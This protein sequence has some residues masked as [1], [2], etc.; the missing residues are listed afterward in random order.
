[1]CFGFDGFAPLRD[2]ARRGTG[3]D[4]RSLLRGAGAALVGG[5]AALGGVAAP[6]SAGPVATRGG[7]GRPVPP[8]QISI[9]MY[10]LRSI[11]NAGTV[12]DV[13][14]TL[15]DIGYRKVELAGTYGYSATDL[16]A[17]LVSH[18]ISA[19]S[20]H[21]GISSGEEAMHTKFENAVTLG[22]RF[23]NVPYLR[24]TS[25]DQWRQWADRMN[26]EAAVARSYGIHYGYHNHAHEFSEVLDDGSRAWDI[27]TDRL[28]PSLVHLEVDL[29][30]AV[31]GGLQTGEATEETASQFAA[32]VIA[33]APQKTL[34]Y[35]VKDREP[36]LDPFAGNAFADVGTGFVDFPQIF[37]DHMVKEFIVENDRP[38]IDPITTARVGYDYLRT[39][40]AE[41]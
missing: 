8:G 10:T 22:Q 25:A 31:T 38:D 23:L 12:D 41:R 5:A 17:L 4:R 40:R 3:P 21:D 13:L 9:Q 20:S 29:F 37:G 6:A 15:S 27:F 35:H 26:A 16:K 30:W 2:A 19:S 39:V 34:Q 1:M 36:G 14:G 11:T 33:A 28:D 18:G 32:D 24:S 7:K